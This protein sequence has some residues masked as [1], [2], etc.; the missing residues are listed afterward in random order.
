MLWFLF[1]IGSL[2]VSRLYKFCS[3]V[4]IAQITS[5]VDKLDASIEA[6]PELKTLPGK[7]L[8][9]SQVNITIVIFVK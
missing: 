9:V 5:T 2:T 8:T 3:Y 6:A 4:Q 1:W 7:V